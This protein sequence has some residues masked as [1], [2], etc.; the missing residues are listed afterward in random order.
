MTGKK[1][2]AEILY[3]LCGL[4]LAGGYCIMISRARYRIRSFAL[5]RARARGTSLSLERSAAHRT[6]KASAGGT[7]AAAQA[8]QR[9]QGP[10]MRDV[11][12]RGT[13]CAWGTW[14]RRD[15]GAP[16]RGCVIPCIQREGDFPMKPAAVNQHSGPPSCSP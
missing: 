14:V 11:G 13:W 7:A 16:G 15:V 6:Q 3:V 5:L 1:V 8:K 2:K 10:W 9:G 12:A 4:L